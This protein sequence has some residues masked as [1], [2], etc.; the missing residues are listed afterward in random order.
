MTK[1]L[2]FCINSYFINVIVNN[3][4]QLTGI[5]KLSF[6]CNGDILV[7][8]NKRILEGLEVY[9]VGPRAIGNGL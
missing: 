9:G 4:P 5:V 2:I 8:S 3:N 7:R 6:H 1:S